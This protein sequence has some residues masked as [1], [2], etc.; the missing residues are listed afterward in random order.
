MDVLDGIQVA[1]IPATLLAIWFAAG[2]VAGVLLM[3]RRPIGFLGDL[4]VG[5][6]GGFLGG[7][8]TTRFGFD[9]GRYIGGLDDKPELKANLVEFLT[10]LIGAIVVLLILRI[11]IRRR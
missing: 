11:L 1:G 10:A 6:L 5:V 9:L 7:W 2:L 4:V 3:G 8:A